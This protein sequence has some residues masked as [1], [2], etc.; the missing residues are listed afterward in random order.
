M[1]LGGLRSRGLKYDPGSGIWLPVAAVASAQ[2]GAQPTELGLPSHSAATLQQQGAPP[3]RYPS[4]LAPRPLLLLDPLDLSS[5]TLSAL[6]LLPAAP[7]ALTRCTTR[8]PRWGRTAAPGLATRTPD[9]RRRPSPQP[10]TT[11]HHRRDGGQHPP[12]PPPTA[13]PTASHRAAHHRRRGQRAERPAGGGK[14][15][16]I[17]LAA[18]AQSS[19]R[20]LLAK[21]TRKAAPPLLTLLT[22]RTPHNLHFPTHSTA[23]ICS[24][25]CT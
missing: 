6:S 11:T 17:E 25:C 20:R 16:N 13:L 19:G 24:T 9:T 12:Q 23:A 18:L 21:T 4:I 15:S 5:S 8:M 2:G 1:P 7:L 22:L 10:V 14:M 3:G